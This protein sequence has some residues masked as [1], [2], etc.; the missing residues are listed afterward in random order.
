MILYTVLTKLKKCTLTSGTSMYPILPK[1]YILTCETKIVCVQVLFKLPYYWDLK[2]MK[3]WGDLNFRGDLNSLGGPQTPFRTLYKTIY[4]RLG[5]GRY[6]NKI[7]V[8]L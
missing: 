7:L 2:V 6:K 1:Y 4:D 5:K 8:T 3:I